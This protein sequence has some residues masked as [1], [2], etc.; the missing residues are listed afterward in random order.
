MA[1]SFDWMWPKSFQKA[2]WEPAPLMS[3]RAIRYTG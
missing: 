3:V 1:I 2:D